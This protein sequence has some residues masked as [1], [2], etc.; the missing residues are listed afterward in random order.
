[1]KGGINILKF[2]MILVGVILIFLVVALV[3]V[4]TKTVTEK[5]ERPPVVQPQQQPQPTHDR[6][7]LRR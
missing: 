2:A 1:M 3:R 7:H 5:K 4:A 6:R